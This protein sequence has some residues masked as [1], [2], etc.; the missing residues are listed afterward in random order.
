MSERSA[1]F[2][3]KVPDFQI[4]HNGT[5]YTFKLAITEGV[6]LDVEQRLYQRALDGLKAT[7]EHYPEAAYLKRLDAIR[8]DYEEGAY[9][10]V[11]SEAVQRFLATEKGHVFL[12]AVMGGTNE[13]TLIQLW[14]DKRAELT[15]V[16]EKA[17]GMSLPVKPRP[18][19]KRPGRR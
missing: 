17:I 5:T 18:K 16:L 14:I 12:L 6:L 7:R 4:E 13:K 9:D 1:A 10:A 3:Q 11:Q 8:K 15:E 2:A 19:A